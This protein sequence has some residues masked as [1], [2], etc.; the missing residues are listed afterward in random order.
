MRTL[1][2]TDW[3]VVGAGLAAIAWVN[4][5]FFVASRSA[6][7]AQGSTLDVSS[8][9]IGTPSV[10]VV[11]DGGYEP[12]TIR[13]RAGEPVKLVFDRRDTSSCTEEIVLPDFGIRKFLPTGQRTTIELTPPNPG[14]Y[15]FMCGMSMLHGRLVAE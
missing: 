8:A 5:Y 9:A 2:A 11:V 10:T 12:A 6:A 14:T 4:W 1:T 7:S 15:D 3:L 13:V